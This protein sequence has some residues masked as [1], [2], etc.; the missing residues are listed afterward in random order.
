MNA[1]KVIVD[2]RE[3]N[4]GITSAL[5]S[6][7][8]EI[9]IEALPVGDYAISDRVCIERKTVSDFES[10]LIDGRLFDQISRLKEH[11]AFPILI[12]EGEEGFRLKSTV[13]NGTI[14]HLYIR[15][16]IVCIT[17]GGSKETAALIASLAKQEQQDERREPSP[18]GGTRAY[19]EK[20]FQEFVVGSLPGVGAKIARSLLEHF[21]SIKKIAEASE[22]ELRAVD[23]IGKK[24]AALISKILNRRYGD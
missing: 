23:K 24:K 1:P 11:Y 5:E 17:T 20:Q 4:A 15:Y 22:E 14:A 9:S 16:G 8:L 13:I 18:K 6:E 19:T 12:I 21:G 3:R 10:S 2:S 7:G